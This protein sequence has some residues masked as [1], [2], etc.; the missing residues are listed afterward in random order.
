MGKDPSWGWRIES[1]QYHPAEHPIPPAFQK[2]GRGEITKKSKEDKLRKRANEILSEDDLVS[3]K[4]HGK[5]NNSQTDSSALTEDATL[6]RFRCAS[7]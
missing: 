6:G 5:V 7:S 1:A 3:T 2:V 4:K